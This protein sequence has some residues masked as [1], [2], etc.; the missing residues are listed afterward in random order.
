MS[1]VRRKTD[2]Y[3]NELITVLQE[4][5]GGENG[6]AWYFERHYTRSKLIVR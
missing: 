3:N 6:C 1:T 4:R 5:E 2:K